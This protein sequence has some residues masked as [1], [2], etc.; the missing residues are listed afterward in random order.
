[1][2]RIT[3]NCSTASSRVVMFFLCHTKPG[4]GKKELRLATG[5]TAS[6]PSGSDK[7]PESWRLPSRALWAGPNES[8]HVDRKPNR[9][10]MSS[11]IANATNRTTRSATL[12]PL[13]P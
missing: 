11:S 3:R 10:P 4:G 13:F 12:S 5:K 2:D 1:M 9:S 6:K 7:H 8:A